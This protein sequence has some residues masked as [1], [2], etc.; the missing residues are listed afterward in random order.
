MIVHN[1][2][3]SPDVN[4]DR[5]SYTSCISKRSALKD[6]FNVETV[7]IETNLKPDWK[8]SHRFAKDEMGIY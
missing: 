5:I 6:R 8:K 2:D 1:N 7:Y 3:R 4:N